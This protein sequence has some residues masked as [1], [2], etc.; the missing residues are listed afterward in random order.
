MCTLL[1]F[2]ENYVHE[3]RWVFITLITA[4]FAGYHPTIIVENIRELLGKDQRLIQEDLLVLLDLEE[5]WHFEIENIIGGKHKNILI[6]LDLVAIRINAW[7]DGKESY[8]LILEEFDFVTHDW[9]EVVY[10]GDVLAVDSDLATDINPP[11]GS[12]PHKFCI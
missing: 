4:Y 11:L 10:E 5:V 7:H 3:I 6:K 2:V 8:L 9:K 1:F 12:R